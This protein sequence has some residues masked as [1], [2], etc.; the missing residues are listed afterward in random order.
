MLRAAVKENLDEALWL[1]K[2]IKRQKIA[3]ERRQR[4]KWPPLPTKNVPSLR[5]INEQISVI[6]NIKRFRKDIETIRYAMESKNPTKA[7]KAFRKLADM[8]KK[9][10]RLDKWKLSDK[11]LEDIQRIP[12]TFYL[13]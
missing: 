10:V 11:A 9:M 8:Y 6:K 4:S 13:K 2:Q 3:F 1:L 5:S 12:N 7:A